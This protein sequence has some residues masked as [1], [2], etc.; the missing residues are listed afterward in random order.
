MVLTA[1]SSTQMVSMLVFSLPNFNTCTLPAGRDRQN[2]PEPPTK[3]R[4]AQY[5]QPVAILPYAT[6][7]HWHIRPNPRQLPQTVNFAKILILAWSLLLVNTLLQGAL[8]Y[9][10]HIGGCQALERAQFSINTGFTR[11]S[12]QMASINLHI[13]QSRRH[14]QTG[15]ELP[16]RSDTL[17][18]CL[19]IIIGFYAPHI[20]CH[21][22]KT[23]NIFFI[24][25][26]AHPVGK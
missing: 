23:P 10:F 12:I 3:H 8:Q 18:R 2:Q 6:N 20:S 13:G 24:E 1:K 21:L 15:K 11:H 16:Y 19:K 5:A 4:A 9:L 22:R 17:T 7:P 26:I 25:H 14:T